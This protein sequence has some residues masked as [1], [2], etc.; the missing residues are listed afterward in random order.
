MKKSLV[1]LIQK[2]EFHCPYTLPMTRHI[3]VEKAVDMLVE[4]AAET[5]CD[6]RVAN[7]SE[8]CYEEKMK[9]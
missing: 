2:N 6:Y 7:E 8:T 9:N 1:V 5:D 4:A 3:V